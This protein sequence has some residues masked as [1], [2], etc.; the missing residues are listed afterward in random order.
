[1]DVAFSTAA[2]SD[3]SAI[4]DVRVC[5]DGRREV[6]HVEAARVDFDTLALRVIAV[7]N[8]FGGTAAIESNGGGAWCISKSGSAFLPSRSTRA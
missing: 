7:C 3:K 4:V 5:D 1:V 2:T 6:V 8:A